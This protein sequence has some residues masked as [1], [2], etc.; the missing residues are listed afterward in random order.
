MTKDLTLRYDKKISVP[1]KQ[2]KIRNFYSTL[3]TKTSEAL[4]KKKAAFDVIKS[5][6][7]FNSKK[8]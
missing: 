3:G 7:T 6:V 8:L 4:G 5:R 2:I 1:I